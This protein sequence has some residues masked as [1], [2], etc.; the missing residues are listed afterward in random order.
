MLYKNVIQKPIVTQ[1]LLHFYSRR[2]L[3]TEFQ[4][5]LVYGFAA[6]EYLYGT[7]TKTNTFKNYVYLILRIH[8][9][10]PF[11]SYIN[12]MPAYGNS[13]QRC[14]KTHIGFSTRTENIFYLFQFRIFE[15]FS[16]LKLTNH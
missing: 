13:I 15:Y 7:T 4:A 1:W 14:Q 6:Y 12:H 9:I 3:L 8:Y 11:Y 2:I 5:S 10:Y 16:Q